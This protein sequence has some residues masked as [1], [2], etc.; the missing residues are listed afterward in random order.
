MPIDVGSDCDAMLARVEQCLN[1][2]AVKQSHAASHASALAETNA[3]LAQT[4]LQANKHAEAVQ[5]QQDKLKSEVEKQSAELILVASARR[6]LAGA[7]EAEQA[8]SERS[9]NLQARLDSLQREQEAAHQTHSAALT[10][11]HT[12]LE[13]E[14][15]RAAGEVLQSACR[16]LRTPI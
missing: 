12:R 1:E 14:S 4:L 9:H 13:A 11:L 5:L 10:S 15:R 16:N 3:K 6:P 8:A 7:L 2:Y